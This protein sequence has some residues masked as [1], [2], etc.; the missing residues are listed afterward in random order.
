MAEHFVVEPEV[1]GGLGERTVMD[2]SSHPPIVSRLHYQF[3]GWLG[4]QIVESFPCYL[5]TESLAA[6]IVRQGM[7]GVE[8]HD[9]EVTCS[10][11]FYEV[12]GATALPKFV[13]LKVTG[14]AGVDDF[15]IAGDL[16]LTV[17]ARVL[18]LI[19]ATMPRGLDFAPYAET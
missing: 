15:G 17:S 4:D 9:V 1:A 2:R 13:W 3:E 16:R 7:T 12:H 14:V 18:K 19:Q 10:Q 5:V 6:E 8:F 11:E